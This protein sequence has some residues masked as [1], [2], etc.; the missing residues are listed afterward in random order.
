MAI[1]SSHND[2]NKSRVLYNNVLRASGSTYAY[3]GTDVDGKSFDNSYDWKDFSLFETDAASTTTFD[4]TVPADTDI[5][6]FSSF[7]AEY[8]GTGDHDIE[9]S[10]ESAP[11]VF[12]VLD[13][14]NQTDKFPTWSNFSS[15]TVLSGRKIRFT[16][17]NGTAALDIR[18]L[19]VGEKLEFEMGQWAGINPVRLNHGIVAS[20]N[21]SINGS[22]LGRSSRRFEKKGKISLDHLNEDWIR[23]N[24]NP[25]SISATKNAFIYQWNPVDY[26]DE[27]AFATGSI[28]APE[29]SGPRTAM[30]VSMNLQ[31]ITE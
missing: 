29:N 24:W 8:S 11:A 23:N 12:T 3:S 20:N 18:Q 14:I 15:V 5:D 31:L 22:I 7:C 2:L 19:V 4:I 28:D 26:P 16:I 9:L 25:F 17:T 1:D 21:I 30:S 27:V 10:Y 13:T 6:T